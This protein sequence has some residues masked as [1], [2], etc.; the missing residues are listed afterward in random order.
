MRPVFLILI[1]LFGSLIASAQ[2][3]T[4]VGDLKQQRDALI[5]AQKRDQYIDSVAKVMKPG[6]LDEQAFAMAK[7]IDGGIDDNLDSIAMLAVRYKYN[8]AAFLYYVWDLRIRYSV[9][10]DVKLKDDK[11]A[12]ALLASFEYIYGEMLNPFLHANIDNY[13][14]IL[15]SSVAWFD[16]NDSQAPP[17]SKNPEAYKQQI[18]SFNKMIAEIEK[19]RAKLVKDWAEEERKQKE[20]TDKEIQEIDAQ[21]K[22]RGISER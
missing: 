3:T 11:T 17:R 10:A 21:L 2:D 7:Q 8:E 6:V 20:L 16:K 12:G 22:Q 14:S 15:R 18:E 9:L 1:L 5:N 13:V 19:N 4:G